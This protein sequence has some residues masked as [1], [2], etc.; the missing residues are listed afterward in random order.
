ML[1]KAFVVIG[2]LI[3]LWMFCLN[4]LPIVW[5]WAVNNPTKVMMIVVSIMMACFTA[6]GIVVFL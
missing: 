4:V 1:I 5:K 6:F 2:M 3:G